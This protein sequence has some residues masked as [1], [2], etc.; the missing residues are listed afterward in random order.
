[1]FISITSL[2]QVKFAP[3]G[4]VLSPYEKVVA[5]TLK[6]SIDL[7]KSST[8]ITEEVRKQFITPNLPLNWKMVRENELKVMANQD[9]F[10][11][12]SLQL[13]R[14]INY[15]LIEN[16]SHAL[17][18][19]TKDSSKADVVLYKKIIAQ[20]KIDWVINPYSI[21]ISN[22]GNKSKMD[23][24]FQ[25]Y[26]EPLGYI[27]LNTALTITEAGITD[28]TEAPLMCLLN[29]AAKKMADLAVDKI[30]RLR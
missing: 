10:S 24:K 12:L 2:S 21:K 3:K 19:V 13:E 25:I 26:Y 14:E 16:Y 8:E 4:I 1:L 15:K 20:H 9:Y 6:D 30:E 29:A 17:I 7:Y 28:C 18:V 27:I 11:M 23:I 5:P 22:V